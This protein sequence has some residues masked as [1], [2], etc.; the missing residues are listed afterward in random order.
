[1]R[2][3]GEAESAN[4]EDRR[5]MGRTGIAVGGV[6]GVVLLV[7]GLIFGVDFGGAGGGGVPDPGGQQ[8]Q[9]G[10]PPDDRAKHFSATILKFTEDVWTEQFKQTDKRYEPPRMVLFAN[11]VD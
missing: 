10:Q 6:G 9:T 2:W 1:M 8:Q 5:G 4:V 11:E 3:E 7:L